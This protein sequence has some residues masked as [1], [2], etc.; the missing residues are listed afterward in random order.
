MNADW[1][2]RESMGEG[3]LL[4]D[5][6]EEMI[7]PLDDA[8]IQE[9]EDA[10]Q[11]E[12]EPAEETEVETEVETGEEEVPQE[13]PEEMPEEEEE[14]AE[15]VQEE[16]FKRIAETYLKKVYSNVK[17]FE[18]DD[19]TFNEGLLTIDGTIEFNSGKKKTTTF[20]F[21]AVN[22]NKT[23]AKSK[24]EFVGLNETFTDKKDALGN[25][26]GES[27]SWASQSLG[28]SEVIQDVHDTSDDA[29]AE[30]EYETK[31]AIISA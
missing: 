2:D 1:F 18:I 25:K 21:E 17:S 19:K 8:D 24:K 15:E 5:G 6:G 14:E 10:Q 22:N 23:I 3:E 31:T 11:P 28:G 16:S 27:V 13:A 30:A 7:A 12:E 4:P 9:I 29:A 20:V 26:I